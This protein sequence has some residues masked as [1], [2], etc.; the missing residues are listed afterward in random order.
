MGK[1]RELLPEKRRKDAVLTVEYVMTASPEWWTKAS[2]DE[3]ADFFNQ[4]HQW[5]VKKYGADRIIT[6][7]I[8]RD[9]KTPHLS[10]FVVPLTQDGRL[11]AKDFIGNRTQMTADQ[12]SFA[13]AV[14]HL[15]LERGIERS[16]STHTSIKQHYA[17]IQKE[18]AGH[19][20]ITPESL[21]PRTF[22]PE[23]IAEK[24]KLC[25][26]V[27]SNEGVAHRL[28]EAVN[29]SLAATFA[30]ASESAQNERRAKELSNTMAQQQKRL[31]TL[32]ATFRGLAK[33][34]IED[35]L[36]QAIKL[37]QENQQIRAKQDQERQRE[38]SH[39]RSGH[40]RGR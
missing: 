29:N 19:V 9:E 2:K 31:E 8:H 35:L 24:L 38:I 20:T 37:G 30:K 34:Q 17:A 5:L 26:R 36:R 18:I 16:K 25:V 32:Q 1:L 14:E 27:E 11:S 15:G 13:K 6:A 12:T 7:T 28:T 22:K 4:A 3:Q 21:K 39:S 33:N 10:A 23:G 40:S